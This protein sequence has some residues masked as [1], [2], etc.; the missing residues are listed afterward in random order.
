MAAPRARPMP[1]RPDSG[2]GLGP[3]RALL[4]DM[5]QERSVEALQRMIVG[6]LAGLP[7]VALARIWLLGPGDICPECPMLPACPDHA[8]C[9]HLVAGAGGPL[10]GGSDW[11]GLGGQF[12]RF[13]IGVYKVGQI[14]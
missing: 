3:Y 6:R 5:A 7:D 14:A 11:S 8:A 2:P 10:R 12:R 13:P 1:P 4:L 9:L